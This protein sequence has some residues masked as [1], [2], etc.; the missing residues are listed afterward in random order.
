MGGIGALA[1]ASGLSRFFEERPPGAGRAA[2]LPSPPRRA[3][4]PGQF[5]TCPPAEPPVFRVWRRGPRPGAPPSPTEPPHTHTHTRTHAHIHT[6]ARAHTHTHTHTH[7]H[8]AGPGDARLPPAPPV[9]VPPRLQAP[10]APL[11]PLRHPLLPLRQRP[12]LARPRLPARPA[13][14]TAA[15]AAAAARGGM[16]A[17]D[18]VGG[19]VAVWWARVGPA[20]GSGGR[21]PG[22]E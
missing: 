17:R 4:L 7:T 19:C 15:A 2:K 6:H 11:H 3:N 10:R 18:P 8:P 20:P 22:P 9:H 16:A 1:H 21:P 5:F 14:R 12:R 13:P